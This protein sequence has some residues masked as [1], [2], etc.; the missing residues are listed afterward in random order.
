MAV[1]ALIAE[2]IQKLNFKEEKMKPF[3]CEI[4]TASFGEKGKLKCHIKT[5]H[6]NIKLY[7]CQIY[8]ATIYCYAPS[9]F[10]GWRTDFGTFDFTFS[11]YHRLKQSKCAKKNEKVHFDGGRAQP[12]ELIGYK[13]INTLKK[14]IN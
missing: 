5:L 12:Y 1:D 11:R 9:S 4:C 10:I 6:E 8:T 14:V 2:Q 3:Q 13:K 7:T